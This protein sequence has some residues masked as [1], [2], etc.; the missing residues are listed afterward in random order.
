M[1]NFETIN[2]RKSH[3]VKSQRKSRKV[4]LRGQKLKNEQTNPFWLYY[5]LS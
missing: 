5:E 1:I 2:I 3:D 4:L